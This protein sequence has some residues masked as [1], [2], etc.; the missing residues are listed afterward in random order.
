MMAKVVFANLKRSKKANGAS[1]GKKRTVGA[2]GRVKTVQTLDA[3]STS[4]GD[5]LQQ[6][7]RRNVGKARRDNKR[8]VGALDSTPRKS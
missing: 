3:A 5:D 2:D 1:I 4:F 7:F 8:V 6:V